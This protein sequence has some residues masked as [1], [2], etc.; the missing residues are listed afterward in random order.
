VTIDFGTG[1]CDNI[2]TIS[3]T[4]HSKTVTAKNDSSGD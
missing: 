3:I 2:Y 4:G 1:T